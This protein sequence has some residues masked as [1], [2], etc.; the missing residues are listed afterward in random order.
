[1][2][3]L[4]LG[5][6]TFEATSALEQAPAREVQALLQMAGDLTVSDQHSNSARNEQELAF[7]QLLANV[8]ASMAAL[9][10]ENT[11]LRQAIIES[12]QR[13][14][15]IETPLRTKLKTA[16]E[17]AS[18]VKEVSKAQE[19][20]HKVAMALLEKQVDMIDG[21]KLELQRDVN[22]LKEER[23]KLQ[24]NENLLKEVVKYYGPRM[25]L[26]PNYLYLASAVSM[27]ATQMKK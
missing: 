12:E 24:F 27:A 4:P 8:Q 23:S 3:L 21:V 19:A 17:A 25:L 14:R 2:S 9:V 1:M 18:A 13:M 15:E 26:S 6:L 11:A 7:Q 16:E 10:Q 22:E 5:S 20:Q